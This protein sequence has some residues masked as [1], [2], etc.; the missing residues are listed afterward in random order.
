MFLFNIAVVNVFAEGSN[1]EELT[2]LKSQV[3][4]LL[5]RIE[6]LEVEQVVSKEESK[7]QKKR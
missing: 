7:R 4:E 3:Q 6:K 2:V 5:K 1:E